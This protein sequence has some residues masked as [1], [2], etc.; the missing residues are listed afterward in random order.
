MDFEMRWEI[1]SQIGSSTP[2]H[3]NSLRSSLLTSLEQ[4][5]MLVA[6]A[7]QPTKILTMNLAFTFQLKAHICVY[8]TEY[9][10]TQVTD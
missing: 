3:R 8:T 9:F 6:G 5:L 2:I 10:F 4:T 7:V 1:L